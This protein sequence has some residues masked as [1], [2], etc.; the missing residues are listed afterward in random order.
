M[1]AAAKLLGRAP[2]VYV[3]G[4]DLVKSD[5]SFTKQIIEAYHEQGHMVIGVQEVPR[6]TVHRYGIVKLCAGSMQIEDIIEK[7]SLHEAP[8]R[9]ADFGRMVLDAEMIDMLKTVPLGRGNRLWMVNAIRRYIQNGG[10]FLA[11]K[12]EGGEWLTTGDP[13]SYLKAVLAYAFDRQDIRGDLA[14]YVQG[15]LCSCCGAPD[16]P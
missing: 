16:P 11:K 1:L 9:L 2:F 15:L 8:S 10:I 5:V 6:E 3:W 14:S 7:P 13:L 4:D 12:V